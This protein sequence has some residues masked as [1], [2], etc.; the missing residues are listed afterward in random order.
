MKEAD[1]LVVHE[2]YVYSSFDD[3]WLHGLF[4]HS[5]YVVYATCTTA[6]TTVTLLYGL[7]ARSDMFTLYLSYVSRVLKTRFAHALIVD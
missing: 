6:L 1:W 5:Q 3:I 4:R 2:D 7:L